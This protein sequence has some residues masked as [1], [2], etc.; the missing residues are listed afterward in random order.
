MAKDGKTIDLI[1]AWC[2]RNKYDAISIH[3]VAYVCEKKIRI[4][5]V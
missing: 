5:V 2:G 3:F 1:Y 4:G